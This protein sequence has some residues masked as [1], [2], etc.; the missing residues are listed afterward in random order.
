MPKASSFC[1]DGRWPTCTVVADEKGVLIHPPPLLWADL[2]VLELCQVQ[3]FLKGLWKTKRYFC[4]GIVSFGTG[5]KAK[6]WRRTVCCQWLA[7][8]RLFMHPNHIHFILV[9]C[10]SKY[11]CYVC[12]AMVYSMLIHSSHLPLILLSSSLSEIFL[13]ILLLW[14]FNFWLDLK[15]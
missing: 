5:G 2:S 13:W 1:S 14:N 12:L 6:L 10:C 11:F 15:E 3:W 4:V 9:P 8:T 7:L